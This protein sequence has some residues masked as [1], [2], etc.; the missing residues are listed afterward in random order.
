MNKLLAWMG[1]IGLSSYEGVTSPAYDILRPNKEVVGEY[2][3]YLFRTPQCSSELKKHSRGIMEMRLRLYFDKFGMVLVPFPP[4][5]EQ[6]AIAAMINLNELEFEEAIE[7]VQKEIS[8]LQEY[9]LILIAN[10]VTGKLDVRE[11]AHR[12]S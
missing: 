1:A 3:H 2:F 11:D 7:R 6:A 10:V 4:T 9:R 12:E 8:L 5:E